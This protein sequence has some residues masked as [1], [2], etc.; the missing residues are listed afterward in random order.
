M[1]TS[2]SY[3]ARTIKG[4][5]PG[6]EALSIATTGPPGPTTFFLRSER[7]IEKSIQQRGRKTS[8]AS[9][10][11]EAEMTKQPES[12]TDSMRDS[13]FGVQS[14][15]ETIS[16]AFGSESTL[17]RTNSHTTDVSVEGGAESSP[18]VLGPRKRKAGNPVHPK[19][20]ATGQRIISQEHLPTQASLAAASASPLSFRSSESPFRSHLRRDGSAHSSSVWMDSQPLTPLRLS[21]Q[22]ES[23]MPSTPRSGSPKSFRLSDEEGSVMDD[24]GSQAVQSSNGDDNEQGPAAEHTNEGS[25]PQLV[26]PSIAMPSRRPFTERGKRMGRLKIMIVGPSGVGKTSLV[27]SIFRECQDI[28][29]VDTV[30]SGSQQLVR[31]RQGELVEPARPSLTEVCAST[32]QYPPWWTDFDGTKRKQQSRRQSFGDGV[33][34]RNLCFCDT[35]DCTSDEGIRDITRFLE[36]SAQHTLSLDHMDDGA[37]IKLL[38]GEGGIGIDAVLW[39]FDPATLSGPSDKPASLPFNN[40]QTRLWELLCA[41][42]NVIPLLAR[43]DTLETADIEAGTTRDRLRDALDASKADTYTFAELT[44]ASEHLPEPLQVSTAPAPDADTI[45]ASILMSSQ[46]IPPLLPSDLG[47]LVENLLD[48]ENIQRMR[49]IAATKLV[50]SRHRHKVSLLSPTFPPSFSSLSSQDAHGKSLVPYTTT[51][52][53]SA[54]PSPFNN[55]ATLPYNQ[56]RL[57]KWAQDLQRGLDTDRRRYYPPSEDN[58]NNAAALT[59]PHRARAGH[60]GGALAVIDP[61]DPLGVLRVAQVGWLVM[62]VAGLGAVAFWIVRG[63]VQ[64]AAPS[65]VVQVEAVAAPVGGWDWSAVGAGVDW[66][67]FF[68]W[69]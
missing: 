23:A 65:T 62:R 37:V 27:H 46:Y 20:Q 54:S 9:K 24:T 8:R 44:P 38:S 15:E 48:P 18:P 32:R 68:G 56:I 36:R 30:A 14:L 64:W 58:N 16:S 6:T 39:L 69:A 43:A 1:S 13:T 66:R 57:A 3:N 2:P 19:I 52:P 60:L 53:R 35:S 26:M 51:S 40:A 29:H 31:L 25:M 55:D 49:H 47:Y 33:L 45:D 34:E 7:D 17:S 12:S 41:S 63:W 50:A 59:I 5:K 21:P 61:R 42:T 28:V 4:R 11:S 22:P 10:A 67:S